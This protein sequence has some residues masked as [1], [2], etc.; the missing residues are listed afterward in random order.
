MYGHQLLRTF[1]RVHA[2]GLTESRKSFSIH[3]CGKGADLL[4]DYTRR[5]GATAK[6]SK[7]VVSRIRHR[8]S[9]AA[10]LLPEDCAKEVRAIDDTID[11]D[12]RIAG[13]LGR[14][15]VVDR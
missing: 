1:E 11:R 9:E 6:V 15:A 8:L 7:D 2:L 13:L 12:L 10:D 3:W 4:R 5:Q 14:R